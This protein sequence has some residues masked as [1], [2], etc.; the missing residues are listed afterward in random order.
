M[1]KIEIY[2]TKYCPYCVKAKALLEKKGVA[3][4]EIHADG[5]DKLREELVVKSGGRKTVPQIFIGDHHIGG[6]DD[7]YALEADGKLDQM[8]K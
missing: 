7:L 4:Q 6:C 1:Q 3:Y 2:T 5:N 8:L